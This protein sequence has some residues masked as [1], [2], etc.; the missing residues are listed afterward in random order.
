MTGCGMNFLKVSPSQLNLKAV[1]LNGQTFRWRNIGECYYGVV[2]G[3][4][5][6]L[7]RLDD[8]FIEWRCLGRS[9]KSADVDASQR[10]REYFQLNVPLESLWDSWCERDPFMAKLKD[11]K[12]LQGIRILKQDFFETLIAFICSANNN[13]PR[14]TKMVNSLAKKYGD[15]I[16]L[17]DPLRDCDVIDQFPELEFAFPTVNQMAG[18]EKLTEELRNMSF[19]YR[20]ENVSEAVEVLRN[21]TVSADDLRRLPYEK[22]LEFLL[23][24]KGV[25]SKVAECVAL[26]SL[27]QNDSVPVDRHVFEVTKKYFLPHLK[28]C[29]LSTSLSNTIMRFHKEKFGAY[30]GWAQAALFTHELE[31]YVDGICMKYESESRKRGHEINRTAKRRKKRKIRAE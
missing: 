21:Q 27:D 17:D 23:T 31:Q 5:Y 4:L 16:I 18:V 6:Y 28:E 10:L 3:I 15:A 1:L 9:Y 24:F 30:A 26:M 25:G 13:I 22:I 20:A 19:G 11:I 29:K 8:D 12:Q 2:N 7:R 14:I